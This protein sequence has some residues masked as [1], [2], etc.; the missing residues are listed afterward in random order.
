MTFRESSCTE[1]GAD[2]SMS[3]LAFIALIF[4]RHN[5]NQKWLTCTLP[6]L[7]YIPYPSAS[8]YLQ[9]SLVELKQANTKLPLPQTSRSLIRPELPVSEQEWHHA[10]SS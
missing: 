10:S 7:L 2:F 1:Q 5:L 6:L 8:I 9:H 3:N 4:Q